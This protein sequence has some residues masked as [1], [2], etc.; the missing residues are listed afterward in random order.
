MP[1]T[2]SGRRRLPPWLKRPIGRGDDVASVKRLL[3]KGKLHTVCEEARC[4]NLSECFREKRATFLILGNTCTRDCRFCAV[5]VG[6]PLLPDPDE[7]EK[8]AET[9]E[10]MG[11]N[12]VV[13]TSVTRDDL[14]DGGAGQ[15]SRTIRE[16]RKR[17][18]NRSVEVLTP[19][20]GG[21]LK[22]V[23]TIC[24]TKPDVY[25]HNVE[26][27]PSLYGKVRPSA[28]YDVSIGLLRHV[29]KNHP[30]ITTK[31]GIMLGLGEKRDE[32]VAV[33]EDLRDADCDLVTIGQYMQPTGM[34]LDVEEY[35][36]PS[37]FSELGSAA[38]KMGFKGVHSGPLVRSSF[39]AEYFKRGVDLGGLL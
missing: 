16:I 15:F 12:Y 30:D 6:I 7:P 31:S 17:R 37:V 32:V 4:P 29:K 11:I 35:I 20:F 24:R 5:N 23:D 21:D 8:V 25:N 27:V 26:T 18:G 2:E 36:A 14:P 13:I 38:K 10:A 34:H 19:D 39:N 3:R 33:L 28:C 1:S 22:A 9:A